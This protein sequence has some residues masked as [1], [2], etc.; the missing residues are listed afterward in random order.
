[1]KSPRAQA[2]T[3]ASTRCSPRH[4]APGTTWRCAGCPRLVAAPRYAPQPGLRRRI[5][6]AAFV[7][8]ISDHNRRLIRAIGDTG[9]PVHVI[10]C[11]VELAKYDFVARTPP[12]SGP[13]RL[14]CVASLEE[15]KGHRYLLQA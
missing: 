8:A 11:G 7:V 2:P 5:D 4:P 1:M 12:P 3:P 14:L 10:H 9:T 13:V 6:E 15:K